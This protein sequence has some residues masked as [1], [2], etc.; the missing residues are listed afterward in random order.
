MR[1]A[2]LLVAVL[3][4]LARAALPLPDTPTVTDLEEFQLTCQSLQ[5]TLSLME[6]TG[7]KEKAAALRT[8]LW[9]RYDAELFARRCALADLSLAAL[10]PFIPA[11]ERKAAADSL[12]S[13]V[14][15][16]ARL[17]TFPVPDAADRVRALELA[18][19]R[20][21]DFDRER[22][23]T[24]ATLKNIRE[25]LARESLSHPEVTQLLRDLVA[26][27]TRAA[28]AKQPIGPILAQA[29]ELPT[30]GDAYK[31]LTQRFAEPDVIEALFYRTGESLAL[32]ATLTALIEAD[33][34]NATFWLARA[35][36]RQQLGW[37]AGATLDLTVA[38]NLT[39]NPPGSEALT[40]LL[41]ETP[42]SVAAVCQEWVSPENANEVMRL[43]RMAQMG[44]LPITELAPA[45]ERT[46]RAAVRNRAR[47]LYATSFVN[48][49]EIRARAIPLI[50]EANPVPPGLFPFVGPELGQQYEAELAAAGNDGA[51]H[52]AIQQRYAA[53]FG[54]TEA[55]WY[56]QITLL[57][58]AGQNAAA[59]AATDVAG[60][61]FS[62]AA[63]IKEA[64]EK[65]DPVKPLPATE[66]N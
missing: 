17:S 30:S 8:Q 31:N 40:K 51:K 39:P 34:A 26:Q 53:L 62:E 59:F 21:S 55:F 1:L 10:N 23:D 29:R 33:P 27:L 58:G 24:H 18:G 46:A 38:V 3:P 47:R 9:E 28:A 15:Q 57:L 35:R 43:H 4:L 48:K 52:I 19:Q 56:R 42:V 13:T 22:A 45:L 41:K 65:A 36:A 37:R 64:R 16:I 49:P 7:Q 11:G 32:E 2:F 14:A 25:Q 54:V 60:A 63:W 20:P 6:S 5:A 12:G 66:K 44:D 50:A 61:M